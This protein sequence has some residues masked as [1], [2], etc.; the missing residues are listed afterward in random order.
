ME[1]LSEPPGCDG[2]SPEQFVDRGTA[3]CKC[4]QLRLHDSCLQKIQAGFLKILPEID[5]DLQVL[6]WNGV[7]RMSRNFK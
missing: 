6:P 1:A 4:P 3:A 2:E 5:W 7:K